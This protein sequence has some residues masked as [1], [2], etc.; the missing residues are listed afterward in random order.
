MID[1]LADVLLLGLVLLAIYGIGRALLRPVRLAFWSRAANLA[2]ALGLGLAGSTTLLFL[3]GLMGWL[4]PVVGWGLLVAG[5][6]L[7]LLQYK[8]LTAD[9]RAA[10]ETARKL[11]HTSKWIKMLL[12][13]AL[14]FV[15]LNFITDLAPPFE[16]D[17]VHQYLLTPRYWVVEGRYWQP[18][19]IWASALPGNMMMLSAWALLLR[20][21][22]SLAA[23][24]TGFGMSLFW[25]LGVYTLARLHF[26]REVAILA[27]VA[28]YTMP[29]A[30]YLAQS[31]KVDMGWAFFEALT[32]AAFF[33]WLHLTRQPVPLI[34][35][36][37]PEPSA[38]GWLVLAGFCLGMAAGSKNQTFISV[39]LLGLWLVGRMALRGDWRGLLR[40]AVSFGAA[41]LIGMLPYYLYNAIVHLNPF[42]PVFADLFVRWWGATPSPRSELGTEVFYRWSVGGYFTNLWN[43]SLGHTRLGFYL[44]FIAGPIFLLTIPIGLAVGTF[45]KKAPVGAMLGYALVFS[46]VWFLVK[47][48]V[49]HFLPGLMLL[50]VAAGLVLWWLAEQ[51]NWQVWSMKSVAFL[52]LIGNLLLGLGVLYWNGAYRVLLGSETRPEYLTRFFEEATFEVFPDPAMMDYLN[53]DLPVG[54]RILAENPGN[55][56]YIE[57]DVISPTW[58]ERARLDTITD[59]EELLSMLDD[60]GVEYILVS[61]ADPD[62]RY[63]FTGP[64]FLAEYAAP[65]F[66]GTRTR[67]YRLIQ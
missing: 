66:E 57:R 46:V 35:D 5:I 2:Y 55:L 58:G 34:D 54:A 56:L 3:A 10:L 44:G 33:R 22:Y 61:D 4:R 9:L 49:R 48:A 1:W 19:F 32:L 21:S 31:A 23:L 62:D 20:D 30:L 59:P 60:L 39:A 29:D 16:G 15:A 50:A 52:L 13:V 63:L 28:A 14:A 65:V 47:Q 67:L 7:A 38:L 45:R 18:P 11:W 40:A 24:V 8:V 64:T 41:T 53:S 6:A 36:R 43:A 37:E 51:R 17:T 25:A 42:Y 26:G 27:V 12:G